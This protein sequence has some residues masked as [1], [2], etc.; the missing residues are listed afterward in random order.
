VAS[1]LVFVLLSVACRWGFR[2]AL[3][4]GEGLAGVLVVLAV[5]ASPS[6]GL[7]VLPGA[8]LLLTGA[9]LLEPRSTRCAN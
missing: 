3:F 6:L 9:M 8:A 4:A 5:L 7:F 2:P 1:L